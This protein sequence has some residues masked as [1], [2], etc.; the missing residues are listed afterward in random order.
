MWQT[1]TLE[2]KRGWYKAMRKVFLLITIMLFTFIM[3]CTNQNPVTNET[4]LANLY[5]KTI[6]TLFDDD[7]GLN[8]DIK[9]IAIQMDTLKGIN[10]ADKQKIEE[11]I[12]EKGYEM[13]NASIKELKEQGEFDEEKLYIKNGILIKIDEIEEF[14]DTR[15][16]FTASK[17]RSGLGAIGLSFTFEKKNKTW[18]LL[19]S[20]MLWI[21]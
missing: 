10:E 21:S 5:I 2:F 1:A 16:V 18:D 20:K 19:E 8:G 11:H 13:K 6:D 4:G 9:F 15:I 14:T 7:P 17:Y 3:G 12:K